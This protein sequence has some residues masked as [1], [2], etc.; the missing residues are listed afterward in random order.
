MTSVQISHAYVWRARLSQCQGARLS[1]VQPAAVIEVKFS[2]D[3]DELVPATPDAV[4]DFIDRS[5]AK[6]PNAETRN[7]TRER[8]RHAL[9]IDPANDDSKASWKAWENCL[10]TEGQASQTDFDR[11]RT[12]ILRGLVCDDPEQDETG[13]KPRRWI[14]PDD[15]TEERKAIAKGI[16]RNWV[17]N[18][19][20]RRKFSARL[21]H[22]LLGL[23]G[24]PCD[25]A[26]Y[27]DE[28][29]NLRLR[30]LTAP[31]P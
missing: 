30:A 12:D 22:D 7:R 4:N 16:V 20:D 19:P 24:K 17:S 5:T 21:A 26:K 9:I 27:F 23:G 3:T 25:G 2:W 15:A 31:S 6:I 29:T 11:S 14:P 28:P 13:R 10:T 1:H 18:E 8:M